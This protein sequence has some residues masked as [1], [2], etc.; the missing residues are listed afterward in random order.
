M[1]E[2]GEGSHAPY[3]LLVV[4]RRLGL[5]DGR[6]LAYDDVGD[7]V[8]APVVYLHGTP[9]S[10]LGRPADSTSAAAGVRLLAVDRPGFGDSDGAPG[11]TLVSLGADLVALLDAEGLDRVVLLGWSGGGLA[12]LAAATASALA[13]RLAAVGLIGTLPPAEAYDDPDVL[14]ALGDGRRAFA[15]IAREVAAAELAAEV[16]PYL[17][18]TPLDDTVARAHVLELAGEVGRA[19][20]GQAPGSVDALTAGLQASIRGGTSGLAGDVER[21]LERGLDLTGVTCPVRTFH[22]SLDE[23]SPPEVGTWLVAR[24]ANAVLDLTPGAGHHL[25]F[26]RWRGILR[27]L[28]R[29]AGM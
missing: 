10:R 24:L 9:D 7:P 1:C 18:P 25:L 2:K 23:I 28:R 14:Q 15:E 13:P 5:P 4:T 8:G 16:A 22:G 20:L 12:A 3:P 11:A 21:Q 26:P 27:A 29:D 6:V 19:E 17:V